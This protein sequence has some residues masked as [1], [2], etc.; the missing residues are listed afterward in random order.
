MLVSKP[1]ADELD[2]IE[3][4]AGGRTGVYDVSVRTADGRIVAL[5]RGK[6]A[7]ISGQVIEGLKEA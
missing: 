6:S 2:P 7:R 5:F 3:R 4:S 1:G